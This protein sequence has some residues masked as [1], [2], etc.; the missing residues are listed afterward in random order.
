MSNEIF[1]VFD[2]KN[3]LIKEMLGLSIIIRAVIQSKK[4]LVGHNCLLDI[5]KIYHQFVD[6]LPRNYHQFKTTIY[7]TFPISF[8][9]KHIAFVAKWKLEDS[10]E[11]VLASERFIM[12]LIIDTF[13]M[14]IFQA[15]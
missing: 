11:D 12:P 5:M 6:Q 8:D 4:P 14:H 7:E 2:A 1:D 13:L 15:A 9:S 3:E 10:S